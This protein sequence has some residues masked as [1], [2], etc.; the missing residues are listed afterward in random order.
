[1]HFGE[2]ITIDGYGGNEEKL[3]SRELV[4]RALDEL[5]LLLGMKKLSTPEVY[6]AKGNDGKDPGGWSGFVV[7]E[8]SHISIHNF[9]KRR[10]LTADVYTCQ[11][12]LDR[13]TIRE[14]FS[15]Q[16]E[17]KDIEENFIRRGTR[18]P[19]DN[20]QAESMGAAHAH[21]RCPLVAE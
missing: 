3:A 17:L 14:Y 6:F 20:I 8:E 12:G 9:P 21:V 7:I 15:E 16:F 5:P 19:Q 13:E 11:N 2:H 18:Y 4:L 10:F 1:M